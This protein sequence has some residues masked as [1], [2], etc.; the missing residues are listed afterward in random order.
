MSAGQQD[1]HGTVVGNAYDSVRYVS[2][3]VFRLVL[4]QNNEEK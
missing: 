2:V 1:W 4:S 3:I